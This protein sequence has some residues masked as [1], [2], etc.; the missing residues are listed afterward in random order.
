MKNLTALV[1]IYC[2]LFASPLF[3][4]NHEVKLLTA[5]ANN[6][7][8]LM[9]PGYLKI[10]VGDTVTF[11]PADPTHNVESVSIPL[12]ASEFATQMGQKVTLNFDHK[13]VYLYKC[14]PHFALG[15]LGVIQVGNG[16]NLAQVKE[17]WSKLQA[18]VVLNKERVNQYLSQV[19]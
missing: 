11:V 16:D 1:T 18:G 5:S 17:D 2:L 19:K 12:N 15:M 6:Q 3:A 14:T 4:K 10:E 13:G 7:T 9:S 8:M